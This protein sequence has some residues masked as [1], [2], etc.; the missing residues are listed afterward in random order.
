ML[1]ALS[2]RESLSEKESAYSLVEARLPAGA[3]KG[4]KI[5]GLDPAQYSDARGAEQVI[6]VSGTLMPILE[7]TD[8]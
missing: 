3:R 4:L 7:A 2:N 6:R 1:G 8:S 5:T